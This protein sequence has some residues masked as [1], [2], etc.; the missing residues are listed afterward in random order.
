MTLVRRTKGEAV[1]LP[2]GVLARMQLSPDRVLLAGIQASPLEYLP[3]VREVTLAGFVAPRSSSDASPSPRAWAKAAAFEQELAFLREGQAARVTADS[4]PGP[5]CTGHVRRFGPAVSPQTRTVEV[6]LEIDVSPAD[7]RPGSLVMARVEAT[8][9]QQDWCRRALLDDWQR[10]AGA[11]VAA[12][13]LLR[14]ALIPDTAGVEALVRAAAAYAMLERGLVPAL[15][16]SAVVDHGALK[17]VYVECM[18][19]MFD[20]VPVTLGPRCGDYFPVLGGIR[21]GQRVA[22]TGAYLLD[23]EAHLNPAV[24]AGYFGASRRG[25]SPPPGV[26][27]SAA[28]RELIARQKVCPVTGADLDSMGGPVRVEVNGHVVF[29]CCEGCEKALRKDPEKYLSRLPRP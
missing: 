2:E 19:G 13:S 12:R 8:A 18:P 23:A 16:E 17:I 7:L 1:P 25:S 26:T 22:T 15:P 24:A 4:L 5:P 11:E 21:A 9:A 29:I 10:Q 27:P 20:A 3:L 28:D 14:P 6:W